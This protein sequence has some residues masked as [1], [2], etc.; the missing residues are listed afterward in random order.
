[1]N[2]I[3]ELTLQ[4]EYTKNN[5]FIGILIAAAPYKGKVPTEYPNV[6]KIV[7]TATVYVSFIKL[8]KYAIY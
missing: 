3:C 1:M 5:Q 2:T 6:I 4:V 7:S 8:D